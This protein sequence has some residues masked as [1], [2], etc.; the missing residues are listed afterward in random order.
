MTLDGLVI[1]NTG[2]IVVQA[3]SYFLSYK[4]I[5]SSKPPSSHNLQSLCG[6]L[7]SWTLPLLVD[8]NKRLALS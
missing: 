8:T 5:P 1:A 4:K 6:V 2:T 3:M 7:A